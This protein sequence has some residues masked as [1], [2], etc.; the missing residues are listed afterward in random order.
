MSEIERTE[1]KDRKTALQY[2]SSAQ[3]SPAQPIKKLHAPEASRA[4]ESS[5]AYLRLAKEGCRCSVYPA[6]LRLLKGQRFYTTMRR[7]PAMDTQ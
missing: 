4:A 7:A 5:C 1:I 3:Q 6:H 2:T